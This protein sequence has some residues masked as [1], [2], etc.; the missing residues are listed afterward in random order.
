MRSTVLSLSI[1]CITIVFCISHCLSCIITPV[2]SYHGIFYCTLKVVE[3]H[4]EIQ[5]Q[6]DVLNIAAATSYGHD[7]DS[8]DVVGT[9]LISPSLGLETD[10]KNS[11]IFP[12]SSEADDKHSTLMMLEDSTDSPFYRQPQ[13]SDKRIS[14]IPTRTSPR[15]VSPEVLPVT[16][17]DRNNF[18]PALDAAQSS[19]VDSTNV[20][21]PSH[22][23]PSKTGSSQK[24][25]NDSHAS[26]AHHKN[27]SH[28]EEL[29]MDNSSHKNIQ[30]DHFTSKDRDNVEPHNEYLDKSSPQEESWVK[31]LFVAREKSIVQGE[32]HQ[33]RQQK[34]G[35]F[36]K[37]HFASNT[38]KFTTM[39]EESSAGGTGKTGSSSHEGPKAGLYQNAGSI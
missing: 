21:I 38:A 8:P 11:T 24:S 31:Q 26:N 16:E 36:D 20:S 34:N 18:K 6:D 4:T 17:H 2:L 9:Q 25:R 23:M 29:T 39:V 22:K 14:E 33:R 28:L 5:N 35:E 32:R 12:V 15:R 3:E 7:N 19:H 30:E 27:T 1:I 37:K 13:S 10:Q